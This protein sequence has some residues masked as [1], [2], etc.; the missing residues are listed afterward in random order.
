VRCAQLCVSRIH[1]G[2]RSSLPSAARCGVP[3]S[4]TA[5]LFGRP[6]HVHR[7]CSRRAGVRATLAILLVEQPAP[8][9]YRSEE[10]SGRPLGEATAPVVPTRAKLGTEISSDRQ[11]PTP[12][13]PALPRADA[14]RRTALAPCLR[15]TRHGRGAVSTRNSTRLQENECLLREKFHT[16]L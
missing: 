11:R 5:V 16:P 7:C 8:P 1:A 14:V 3:A 2:Q 12:R 4:L 9:F 15:A 6:S 10:A 13:P